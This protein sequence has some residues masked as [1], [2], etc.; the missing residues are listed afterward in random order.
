[1][2]KR[3]ASYYKPYKKLFFTDM[4]FALLISISDLVFPLFTRKMINEIIPEGRMDLLVRWTIVMIFLFILRYASNYFVLYWG[5]ILGVKI[6]HDMRRDIF[7]HL[8]SLPFSYYDNTKTGHIMSRIVNDLRDI[9]E[10]A[11]HGPEDLFIS[12]VM[13]LGSFVVLIRIEWRL[14]LILFTFIPIAIWFIMSKRNRMSNSFREVRK[15]IAN[16]NSQLENSISGIR[17]AKSFTNEEY[18]IEKFNEGNLKFSNAR[19]GSYKVMAE[20][21]AGI[22]VMSSILN[23]LVISLGGYFVYRGIINFGDLFSFTLYVNFFMQPIRRLSE[24]S[25]QL[26]DGMTGF[27]RF[28]EIMNIESDIIDKENAVELDEVKGNIKFNNVSFSYNNGKNT[29]LSNLNLSIEA[30]KTVALVGPS[31]AGKTTLCHLIPRF[32]EIE[33]GEILIDNIDIRDIKIKSLR[34]KIGLVQQEVFL[35]TGTIRD[36][37][38][39]GNPEA[40]DDEIIEAAKKARIHDFILSLPDGYNTYIGEK[41][42]KLSGGQKQR[43]SIARLFLKNPPILILDEA[44]SA[45]DNETEI[46]IQKSLEDLSKGRTTL[47]IAHR[48]STIKNADEILV[49]TSDGIAESGNHEELLKEDNLYAKLYKSQFKDL[50]EE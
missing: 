34:K 47:V 8:Q 49:L 44:T 11:H 20:F 24:F 42:V 32:Y 4:F 45:L 35:F 38:I 29:V 39:Y 1:M 18:E 14:T 28:V 31:G 30:G 9:T 2:I 23:L 46:M 43:I 7:S 22:G 33:E 16:V 10:L 3:F 6:E 19:K 37:I 40:N 21:L 5:H 15:K 41:G 12:L 27:E 36:N 25:Q 50:L 13:L 26:Q 48:L 17:V